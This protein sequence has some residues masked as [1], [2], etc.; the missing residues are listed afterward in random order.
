MSE[1]YPRRLNAKE[2]LIIQ[3]NDEFA[4]L[5]TDNSAKF[6]GRDYEFQESTLKREYIVKKQSLNGESHD[7]RA[8]SQ[9]EETKDD[10]GSTEIFLDSRRSL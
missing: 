4:C 6:S 10:E 1:T 8:E 3:K 2:V 5:V 9:S 7:D